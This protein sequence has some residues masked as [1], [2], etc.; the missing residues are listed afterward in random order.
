MCPKAC[1]SKGRRGGS[2]PDS[3]ANDDD[4]K[5][6]SLI[7]EDA[8][9]VTFFADEL[10]TFFPDRRL[11]TRDLIDRVSLPSGRVGAGESGR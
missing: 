8:E 7:G 5:V 11:Y 10:D 6:S 1:R 9:D 4:D 3:D 2:A